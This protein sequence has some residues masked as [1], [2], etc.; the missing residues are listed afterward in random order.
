VI[1][2]STEAQIPG[3]VIA[4]YKGIVQGE[5]WDELL[6]QAEKTGANAVLNTR[7]DDALDVDTLFHGSAV[8]L[9]RVHSP[10]PLLSKPNC[11]KL[12]HSARRRR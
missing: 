6:R 8:V 11:R 1:L 7:F 9:K 2:T 5:T 3:Y 12:P 10:G 4:A